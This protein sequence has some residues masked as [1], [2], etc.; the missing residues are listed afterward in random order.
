MR[1]VSTNN[2]QQ[3]TNNFLVAG[4]RTRLDWRLVVWW[5]RQSAGLGSRRN[6]QRKFV[7]RRVAQLLPFLEDAAGFGDGRSGEVGDQDFGALGANHVDGF[8]A[9]GQ[10]A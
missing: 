10:R 1:V 7:E 6:I 3:A 5:R 4:R 8:V 2:Q 9:I